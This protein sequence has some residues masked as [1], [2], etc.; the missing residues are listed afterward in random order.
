[1]PTRQAASATSPSGPGNELAHAAYLTAEQVGTLLQLSAK[2]IY[3][4]AKDDPTMPMLKL[5]GAVRFPR[6]RLE[7]WL[8]DREQGRAQTRSLSAV[9]PKSVGTQGLR[10]A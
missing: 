9:A 8:R 3:R 10:N 7:R 2:S 6:E 1:M 5:G 4:L